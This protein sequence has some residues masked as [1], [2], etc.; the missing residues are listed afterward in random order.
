MYSDDCEVTKQN[1]YLYACL[2]A[3]DSAEVLT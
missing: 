1:L 2:H 3:L